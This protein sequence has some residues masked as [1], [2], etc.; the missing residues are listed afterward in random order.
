ME[1]SS[2]G[3]R[4]RGGRRKKKKRRVVQHVATKQKK[5]NKK[6]VSNTISPTFGERGEIKIYQNKNNIC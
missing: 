2:A 3:G 4:R 5:M 1:G 6:D